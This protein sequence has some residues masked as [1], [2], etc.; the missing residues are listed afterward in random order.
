MRSHYLGL[1]DIGIGLE[2]SLTPLWKSLISCQN[3]IQKLV[4]L[5]LAAPAHKLE[6][7]GNLALSFFGIQLGGQDLGFAR[8]CRVD[9]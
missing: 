4:R 3:V 9:N 8:A 6:P 5:S 1:T 7:Q 2:L